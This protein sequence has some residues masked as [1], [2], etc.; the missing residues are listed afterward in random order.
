MSDSTQC[1]DVPTT[2]TPENRMSPIDQPHVPKRPAP[3][4]E[5]PTKPTH[6]PSILDQHAAA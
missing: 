6:L 3:N 2:D 1:D 5:G 4:S